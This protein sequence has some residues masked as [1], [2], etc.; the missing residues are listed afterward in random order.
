[1]ILRPI[2][3]P[4]RVFHHLLARA[5]RGQFGLRGQAADDGHLGDAGAGSAGEGARCCV[6][7]GGEGEGAA[8][9]EEGHF[10]GR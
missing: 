1:M 10:G 2:A 8:E 3:R 9:E 7:E 4:H 6:F 5:R